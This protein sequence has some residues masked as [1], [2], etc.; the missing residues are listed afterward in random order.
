MAL[1]AQGF[2]NGQLNG[3]TDVG[4]ITY[5]LSSSQVIGLIIE[6]DGYGSISDVDIRYK[7]NNSA[8]SAAIDYTDLDEL[9]ETHA[10]WVPGA[11]RRE[12]SPVNLISDG[13]L[14]KTVLIEVREGAGSWIA[15]YPI[16]IL[17]D[18]GISVESVISPY[19]I[20]EQQLKDVTDGY[21]GE[22]TWATQWVGGRKAADYKVLINGYDPGADLLEGRDDGYGVFYDFQG[23]NNRSDGY[24]EI[25]KYDFPLH[26]G[27]NPLLIT[28]T[29]KAFADDGYKE[30]FTFDEEI[31][32]ERLYTPEQPNIIRNQSQYSVEGT[33]WAEEGYGV[34]PDAYGNTDVLYSCGTLQFPT[35]IRVKFL[36]NRVLTSGALVNGVERDGYEGYGRYYG[37]SPLFDG[38]SKSVSEFYDDVNHAWTIRTQGLDG[39]GVFRDPQRRYGE[40]KT[41]IK[42]GEQIQILQ[43][44]LYDVYD[45]IENQTF[46]IQ[47][48]RNERQSLLAGNT[49]IQLEDIPEDLTTIEIYE[50][51]DYI[52][53]T[54]VATAVSFDEIRKVLTVTPTSISGRKW[55]RI[56]YTTRGVR[57]STTDSSLV[58]PFPNNF[59]TTPDGYSVN[60]DLLED[61][62]LLFD[63]RNSLKKV[64]STDGYGVIDL[65]R[66]YE[67]EL[68]DNYTYHK[69]QA[70]F[71]NRNEFGIETQ[72]NPG[73][74]LLDQTAFAR[75]GNIFNPSYTD[76]GEREIIL[77]VDFRGMDIEVDGYADAYGT[78]TTQTE[79]EWIGIDVKSHRSFNNDYDLFLRNTSIGEGY[80]QIFPAQTEVTPDA[81]Y[82]K[83]WTHNYLV[84]DLI[85]GDNVIYVKVVDS[86]GVLRVG[87]VLISREFPSTAHT[88]DAYGNVPPN[89][90]TSPN[91]SDGDTNT[92]RNL[93][94]TW[95][96]TDDDGDLITCDFYLGKTGDPPLVASGLTTPFQYPSS[97]TI[98]VDAGADY[99]WKVVA[100]DGYGI[101]NESQWYFHVAT[102]PDEPNSPA[103][104]DNEPDVNNTNTTLSWQSASA[105]SNPLTYDIYFDT[106]ISP[107]KIMDGYGSN[108]YN[109]GT[110]STNAKYF[111]KIV[112]HDDKGNTVSS[113]VWRF[114][115]QS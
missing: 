17:L 70:Y 53:R 100:D 35:D 84:T 77:G 87:T 68:L 19:Y 60:E 23:G 39:Y 104:Y 106:N 88:P 90:P 21:G 20:P 109:V 18:A 24:G 32:L 67:T 101:T 66:I 42:S 10:W 58:H 94:F 86:N 92:A 13:S 61:N 97:G 41:V 37:A 74:L 110:L 29:P 107:T 91:P 15:A 89:A 27:L 7:V 47:R 14:T 54:S 4:G 98:E 9:T 95:T 69:M 51:N 16:N 73:F 45:E 43:D 40:L 102:A 56:A 114:V 31:F 22:G 71:F 1:F 50:E 80:A 76:N 30:D 8:W 103:P 46:A 55:C 44:A 72:L 5:I 83:Q 113:P 33:T 65:Q 34:T 96:A 57:T 28:L 78:H 59:R 11:V 2:V 82:L 25:W 81:G 49:L 36:T 75:L 99:N 85:I 6:V 115:T 3:T 48:A 38:H 62:S 12:L 26:F 105:E 79:E 112:V 64:I 93:Q 63:F 108:S 52:T 111:W